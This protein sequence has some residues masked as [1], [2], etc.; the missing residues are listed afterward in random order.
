MTILLPAMESLETE[1]T[2]AIIEGYDPS[3]SSQRVGLDKL[4]ANSAVN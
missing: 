3:V 4:L 1:V 2:E